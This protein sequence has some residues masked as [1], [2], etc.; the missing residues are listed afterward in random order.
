M[1]K[2]AQKKAMEEEKKNREYQ[3]HSKITLGDTYRQSQR[4]MSQSMRVSFQNSNVH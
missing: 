2:K 3:C 4:I 1:E